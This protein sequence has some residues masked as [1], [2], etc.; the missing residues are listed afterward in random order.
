VRTFWA[1]GDI[2]PPRLHTTEVASISALL[3]ACVILTVQAGPVLDFL[4]RTSAGLHRPALYIER[5]LGVPAVPGA[6]GKV[7]PP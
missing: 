5:V 3:L 2:R 7:A 1:A 4:T 6:G